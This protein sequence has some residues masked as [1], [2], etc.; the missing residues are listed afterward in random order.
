MRQFNTL[1]KQ[2]TIFLKLFA[3]GYNTKEA[4]SIM[5]LSKDTA[6]THRQ[7]ILYYLKVYNIQSA[8]SRAHQL[9]LITINQLKIRQK[10]Y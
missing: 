10:T 1:T 5:C 8:V 6:R 3:S 9:K 4:A 2:E 7:N